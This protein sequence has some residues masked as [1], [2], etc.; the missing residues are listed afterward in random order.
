VFTIPVKFTESRAKNSIFIVSI[1]IKGVGDTGD[2]LLNLNISENIIK[3]VNEFNLI[4]RAKTDAS[5]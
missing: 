3:T 2:K 1:L 4:I 5:S